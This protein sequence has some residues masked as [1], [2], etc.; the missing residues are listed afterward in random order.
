[1]KAFII[2]SMDQDDGPRNLRIEAD[3]YIVGSDGSIHFI[4]EKHLGR[5]PEPFLVFASGFWSMCAVAPELPLDS[6]DTIEVVEPKTNAA[7]VEA[8]SN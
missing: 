8:A 5:P 1:M 4:Q 3:G 7:V 2:K 6:R